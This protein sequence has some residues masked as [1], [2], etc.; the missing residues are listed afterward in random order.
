[1]H[2]FHMIEAV[3]ENNRIN[4]ATW[5]DWKDVFELITFYGDL[6]HENKDVAYKF[7]SALIRDNGENLETYVNAF[8]CLE[9]G[10]PFARNIYK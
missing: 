3:K 8:D 10:Q 6:D 9:Y 1:M 7:L 2:F 5:A 4:E